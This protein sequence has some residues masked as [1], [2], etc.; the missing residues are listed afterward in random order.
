MHK[1]CLERRLWSAC[2]KMFSCLFYSIQNERIRLLSQIRE[3]QPDEV[4]IFSFVFATFIYKKKLKYMYTLR[5]VGEQTLSLLASQNKPMNNRS[6]AFA[7]A[8][9]LEAKWFTRTHLFMLICL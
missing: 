7:L 3:N 2:T 6:F 9:A 1:I 4:F 8:L 5:L